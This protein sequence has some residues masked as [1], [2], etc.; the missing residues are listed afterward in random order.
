MQPNYKGVKHDYMKM[1]DINN[2]KNYQSMLT[3]K[4]RLKSCDN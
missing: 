3:D 4:F 1:A 2:F